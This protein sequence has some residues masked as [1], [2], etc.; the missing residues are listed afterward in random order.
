MVELQPSRTFVDTQPN[1]IA[2]LA[3]VVDPRQVAAR[4]LIV[5][6][7][8]DV[9]ELLRES[10]ELVGHLVID[11]SNGKEALDVLERTSDVDLVLLD[12]RMPIMDGWQ[13]LAAKAKRVNLARVPVVVLSAT[14]PD[15]ALLSGTSGFLK[16]PFELDDLLAV[17]ERLAP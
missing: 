2:C 10:L 16:K 1:S 11:A 13:F 3:R 12:L 8:P 6:D 5:D 14:D 15:E 4:I 17:A 9:R 7:D